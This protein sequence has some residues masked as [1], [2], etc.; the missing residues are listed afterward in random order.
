LRRAVGVVR[1]SRLGDDP[2][3][4]SE[5]AERIQQACVRDELTLVTTLDE[6]NVSGG[7]PLERRHGL[8]QAVEL[9]ESGQADVVVVAY[10]DRLVRSLQVQ[11]EVVERIE[12]AGGAIVAVDVG[13]VRSDTASRWLSSTMLGMVAEHHRRVTAERTSEAKR[14]AI[15]DGRP[16][17]PNIPPGLHQRKDGR[18]EPHPVEAT[19]V[20]DAFDLRANGATVREVRD[21]L[22]MNGIERSF[23]GVQ[24]MLTS[25]MYL[26][27][28][29]FGELVNKNAHPAIIDL[30]TWKKVQRM[31]ATR[32]RR[33]KS[34]RL[35]ARLGV[36]RCATCG[37]KM[38]IGSSDPYGKGG[39]R[40]YMYRCPPTGD[41]PR[42]VSISADI[43][44]E[45]VREAVYERTDQIRESASIESEVA[46]A[47][48]RAD[49]EQEELSKLI[50]V[51]ASAAVT[52]EE[53][54]GEELR[55]ARERRD[56]AAEHAAQLRRALPPTRTAGARDMDDVEL[57]DLIRALRTRAIVAPGRGRDRIT[58][59]FLSK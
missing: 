59:E 22:R 28:L 25:R 35:L 56:Q 40:Y 12:R 44:E 24:A 39:Q 13:E 58:V 41:C 2:V 49:V 1:V 29:H 9:I 5:Q 26:G 32:G 3:S 47:D 27:E 11:R 36:L 30:A 52:D 14:R 48:R 51:F 10:F 23:H 8:R 20:R 53:E 34:E 21:F 55:A 50:R 15:A 6:T 33:A 7:A 38:V 45:V 54:A 42:R 46:E 19:L 57:R 17:F 43:A 31:R 4:P 16:T 37:A 18:L